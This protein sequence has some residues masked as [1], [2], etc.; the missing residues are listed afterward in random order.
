MV[1]AK[2]VL[3]GETLIT[4]DNHTHLTD[5]GGGKPSVIASMLYCERGDDNVKGVNLSYC[6]V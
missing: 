1:V 3:P 4:T 2:G 5:K 6:L